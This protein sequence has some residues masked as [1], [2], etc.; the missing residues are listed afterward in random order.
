MIEKTSWLYEVLFRFRD[1]VLTGAHQKQLEVVR[2]TET[3]EVFSEREGLAEAITADQATSLIG[4]QVTGL[5]TQVQ[6]LSAEMARLQQ[7][8]DD[9][10]RV[11]DRQTRL[12][13]AAQA[14]NARLRGQ[15][16]AARALIAGIRELCSVAAPP[17]GPETPPA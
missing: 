5:V 12:L 14:D 13:D 1:G 17:A 4:A 16:E 3:G 15:L 9:T 6:G 2:D 8:A 7:L 10:Q 11:L